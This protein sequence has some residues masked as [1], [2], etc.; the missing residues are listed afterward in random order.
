VLFALNIDDA[1]DTD[2]IFRNKN[3]NN[4]YG[5]VLIFWFGGREL[6]AKI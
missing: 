6:K 2:Y 5:I 1:I 3:D 4:N